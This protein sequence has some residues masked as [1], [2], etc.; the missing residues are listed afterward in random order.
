MLSVGRPSPARLQ[1]ALQWASG[2][3]L[4]YPEVGATAG[5]LPPGYA[6]L[7]REVRLGDGDEVFARANGALRHWGLH[8]QAGLLVHPEAQTTDPGVTVTLAVPL[9]PVWRLASCR[10]VW[11]VDEPERA[12]FAYGT[13]PG[14]PERG[15]EAFVVERAGSGAVVFRLLVFAQ[16]AT[17]DARLLPPAT[18]A[19]QLYYTSRYLQAMRELAG[20]GPRQPRRQRRRTRPS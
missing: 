9:G 4:T 17:V 15:E 8:R 20:D 16:P 5:E 1:A 14:H 19:A 12:G 6:H 18:R 2:Q 10:V 3:D 13:L 7:R 11:A